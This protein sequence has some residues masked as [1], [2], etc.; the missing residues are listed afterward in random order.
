MGTVTVGQVQREP[1]QPGCSGTDNGV[2]RGTPQTDRTTPGNEPAV[3][4]S[5]RARARRQAAEKLQGPRGLSEA[6]TVTKSA[7]VSA[8]SHVRQ[9]VEEL[10]A[11]TNDLD[12]LLNVVGGDDRIKQ[13]LMKD[14]AEILKLVRGLG[15]CRRA[16]QKERA[17]SMNAIVSEI[18]SPPRVT[19]A[20]KMLPSMG[21]IPGFAL[22]LTT[23]D[24]EGNPWD[25][26]CPRQRQKAREL[27]AETKP[28]FLVDHLA[29]RCIR[30]GDIST[31]RAKTQRSDEERW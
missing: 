20:L 29:A 6:R 2:M 22:D 19:Q 13:Q 15:G 7:A 10:T 12:P 3:G 17:K 30:R 24:E 11:M 1:P 5:T 18:Y 14:E 25:F 31:R 8:G 27:R 4:L 23:N 28:Y 21:L 16:Y 26:S 9:S